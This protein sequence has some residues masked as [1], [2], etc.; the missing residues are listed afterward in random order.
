MNILITGAWNY[1]LNEI[2][3]IEKMGHFVYLLQNESDEISI[4]YDKI[5]AVICNGLFLYHP[6]QKFRSLKYIQL[7]SVGYDRVDM[8]YVVQNNIKIFNAGN[9]YS[10]PM[11]EFVIGGL[12]QIYK[13]SQFFYE[14]QKR[15]LWQKNRNLLELYDQKIT[16][17][18]CGNLGFEIAKRLKNFGC[19]ITGV[20]LKTKKSDYFDEILSF[21]MIDETLKYSDVVILSV[22]L[23]ELTYK[24]IDEKKISLM[25]KNSIIINVSRGLIIDELALVKALKEKKISAAILDVFENEPLRENELWELE[26]VIITPHNSFVSNGNSKRLGKI[27]IENLT[28]INW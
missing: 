22:P 2:D 16:I 10:I 1:T 27:I 21:D 12:L 8:N 3:Y 5:D 7:T 15:K 13:K 24:L 28:K 25:K 20:D 17:V 26:N 14:N 18:G 19:I 6:I 23:T 9:A 11:A 4:S